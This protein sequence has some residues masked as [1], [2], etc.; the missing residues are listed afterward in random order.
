MKD[1]EFLNDFSHTTNTDLQRLLML[2][3]LAGSIM[4]INGA[5]TYRVEDTMERICYSRLGVNFSYAFVIPSAIFITV[6]CNGELISSLKRVTPEATNLNKIHLVNSFSRKFVST[7]LTIEE[8]L[9]EI[10]KINN[11]Q[12]YSFRERLLLSGV[13]TS[14]FSGMFGANLVD[15]GLSF[16]IGIITLG[17]LNILSSR[18]FITFIENFIAGSIIAFLSYFTERI[19][20]ATNIDLIIIGVMMPLLPGYALTNAIRDAI[21]G[22]H[23]SSLS[24]SIDAI[25]SGLALALGV[26]TILRFI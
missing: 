19:G 24:R 18:N 16:L 13:I 22:D 23:V 2:S 5:E 11:I 10:N 12:L 15:M 17:F 26:G 14:T 25:I 1:I 6:S 20:L 8:G 7:D 3:V 21:S 9:Q 4:L